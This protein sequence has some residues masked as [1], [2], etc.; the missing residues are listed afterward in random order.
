MKRMLSFAVVAALLVAAAVASATTGHRSAALPVV[1]ISET[2]GAVT[3]S[4]TPQSGA[5][6]LDFTTDLPS[7][8]DRI[9]VLTAVQGNHRPV[10]HAPARQRP[11]HHRASPRPG[12]PG[13]RVPAGRG[14][15][16]CR[17]IP[18]RPEQGCTGIR[19]CASTFRPIDLRASTPLPSRRKPPPTHR[20]HRRC[21]PCSRSV[22]RG[23]ARRRSCSVA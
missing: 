10:A 12:R 11:G 22:S 5:T 18:H 21:C 13:P 23:P 9:K 20:E 16:A 8:K 1:Q 19:M 14:R 6:E 3:V 17:P 7:K 2:G 15:S 4:P